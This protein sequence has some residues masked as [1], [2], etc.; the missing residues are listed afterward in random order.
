[1]PHDIEV[2]APV[3]VEFENILTYEALR[4]LIDLH[5]EFN[6]TRKKLLALRAQRW[7]RIHHGELPDFL[8]ETADIR[9]SQWTVD[10]IPNEIKNRR[11]EITGP[12]NDAKMVINALNS[13]AQAYMGDL[14]DS[15]TPTWENCLRGQVN[16]RDAVWRNLTH[17]SSDGKIYT[18]NE[19]IAVLMMRPRGWHL[20]EAHVFVDGEPI[21]ASLFDFGLF[22]WHNA[23]PLVNRGSRPYLY[24]P[25]L[26]NH[27]EAQLWNNI[28]LFVQKRLE[29][30][31]G[32]IK[33]TVLIETI[34]AAFE[35][36]EILFALKE[37]SVG[38]N[39]GRW[40]YIF[41][42]IKTFRHNPYFVLPDRAQV[43][44]ESGFLSAY[45][46]LLIQT[47]H[48]RG[49]HA[50]GGMAAQIPNRRDAQA[51]AYAL[52]KVRADKTREVKAGHDGTWV[53]HPDLVPVARE[54]FDWHM[55]THNQIKNIPKK[56]VDRPKLLQVPGGV[57]TQVGVWTNIR[58][59]LQYLES[60][61]R[62]IGC[63]PINHCMEDTATA[64]ICRVQL[65]Q[66]L[67]HNV[68]LQN[69]QRVTHDW[70]WP[71]IESEF[72]RLA[73]EMS[74]PN[75]LPEAKSLLYYLLAAQE[76]TE[77]LTIPAYER[78]LR[79]EEVSDGK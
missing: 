48:R 27:H 55:G 8:P 60:W 45:A 75:M 34:L 17:T 77:F 74:E 37:H 71:L 1:M 72:N 70:L 10:P 62:G 51:N 2:R 46:D 68:T 13:G 9:M 42:F 5:R 30:Q 12:A 50:M 44:M 38:L 35:M 4:F 21:S 36:D 25:K 22:F 23:W 6:P 14:E 19:N 76:F 79:K 49:A 40:D 24:L 11:V 18:L 28:F 20:N 78:I 26:E 47:C 66:W 43:T 53:A 65:W 57:V 54:A 69:G 58:V 59:A 73:I 56:I 7:D 3:S 33:A 52:E 67:H 32:T 15:M 39:C 31:P 63:V 64:E 16:L 61:L 41:S 29:L